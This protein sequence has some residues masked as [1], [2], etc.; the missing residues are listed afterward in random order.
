M[1][2]I[3]QRSVLSAYFRLLKEMGW[4]EDEEEYVITEDEK[5]E[6]QK[7]FQRVRTF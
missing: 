5:K 4:T 1:A 7:K 6:T 3:E 2:V